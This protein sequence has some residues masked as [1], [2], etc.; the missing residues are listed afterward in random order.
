M[1]NSLA[2][3]VQLVITRS[4]WKNHSSQVGGKSNLQHSRCFVPHEEASRLRDPFCTCVN[5]RALLG[6]SSSHRKRIVA[7]LG[8]TQVL[9]CRAVKQ[10]MLRI[11]SHTLL[12]QYTLLVLAHEASSVCCWVASDSLSDDEVVKLLR[13]LRKERWVGRQDWRSLAI[14]LRNIGDDLN[15]E[16][17]LEFSEKVGGSVGDASNPGPFVSREQES[18]EWDDCLNPAFGGRELGIGTLKA[19]AKADDPEGYE[20]LV[21]QSMS[22][23]IGQAIERD[24]SEGEHGSVTHGNAQGSTGRLSAQRGCKACEMRVT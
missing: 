10:N 16:S 5:K 15:K 4:H 11:S 23:L 3:A 9:L 24:G 8:G 1:Q 6:M 21:G 2:L 14:M 12:V 19:W 17:W 20:H 18:R 7:S 13:L 22:E